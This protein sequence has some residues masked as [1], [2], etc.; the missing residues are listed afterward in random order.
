MAQ[1]NLKEPTKTL[2]DHTLRTAPLNVVY[3]TAASIAL[4]ATAGAASGV[5]RN[6]P[7]IPAA[8]K[9]SINTGVFAFTFFS[10]RE[11][12]LI[13]LLTTASLYPSPLPPPP[14]SAAP[15][16]PSPHTHNLLPTSL[17]GALA[18]VAFSYFQRGPA[19]P[20]ATH[21]RAGVTLA[22]GCVVLQGIVNEADIIRI[23]A[24][25]RGEDP[26]SGEELPVIS[27]TPLPGAPT[28]SPTAPAPT[29]STP[30]PSSSSSASPTYFT[31]LTTAPHPSSPTTTASDPG[32]ET[33]SERSDRLISSAFSWLKL[34]AARASPVKRMEEGEWEK[35]LQGVLGGVEEEREKVRRERMELEALEKRL[36]EASARERAK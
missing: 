20:L 24:L 28:S 29:S 17:S 5:V 33:F 9:T 1:I 22:L 6:A 15:P 31:D 21:A 14:G 34:T 8:F 27:S 32:R 7:A 13:P 3:G 4:G 18:G 12:A 10:I 19:T 23:R 2:M 36:A 30:L 35:K 11:Y 16:P 25:A 26:H